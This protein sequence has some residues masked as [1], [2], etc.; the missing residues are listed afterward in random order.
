VSDRPIVVA[1]DGPAGSGKSTLAERLARRLRLPY[2]NTGL[3]Y[4]AVAREA[5]DRGI[6]PDDG[7]ALA[8]AAKGLRFD[9]SVGATVPVLRIDGA[10]PGWDLS[11]REVEETVSRVSSHPQVREVLRTA[12]RRL[13]AGGGVIEGRDVGSVVFPDADVKVFLDAAPDVRASR[14]IE[15]RTGH[16]PQRTTTETPIADALAARNAADERTTPFVPPQ[17]AAVLDTTGMSAD[18]VFE[19][20]LNVVREKTGRDEP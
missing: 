16:A 19:A 5:R 13:G 7:G 12:Q 3:M 11:S 6:S 10:P 15:E 20:V 4:R 2:V 9:L 8:E 14:R 1:I 17:D 18:A